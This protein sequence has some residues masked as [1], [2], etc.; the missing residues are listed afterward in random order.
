MTTSIGYYDDR[1]VDN[2]SSNIYG[3]LAVE[4]LINP[5]GTWRVKAYTR[6]GERDDNF[7]Y[8]NEGFNNYVAGVALMYK[9]DFDFRNRNRN[10]S[11]TT[12]K[13]AKNTKRKTD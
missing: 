1:T 2:A 12:R 11:K 8:L 13:E 10:R 4:Y 7:Y 5:A 6:I 9:Q 3:N